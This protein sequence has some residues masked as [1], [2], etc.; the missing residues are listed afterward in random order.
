LREVGRGCDGLIRPRIGQNGVQPLGAPLPRHRRGTAGGIK[1][2]RSA[3]SGLVCQAAHRAMFGSRVGTIAQRAAGELA[4][5][6]ELRI[7]IVMRPISIAPGFDGHRE[8][9]SGVSPSRPRTPRLLLNRLLPTA[10]F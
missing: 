3:A 7:V 5:A 2:R 4:A 10:L 8:C 1:W 6:G 9:P